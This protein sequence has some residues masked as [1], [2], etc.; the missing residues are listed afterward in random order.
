MERL[1]KFEYDN[2]IYEGLEDA[3]EIHVIKGSF[4]NHYEVSDK[5]HR[6]SDVRFLPPAVPSKIVCVGQNYLG[7]IEEL[8]AP[9]P[10]QP[11]IFLKP[12]SCLIGHEHPIIYPP[13]AGRIDYEGE[14]AIV[15][16]QRMKNVAE[17]DTLNYVLGYSCFN[18]VTERNMAAKDPFLLNLA[19]GFDSFGAL[20]PWIVTD[21]DPNHLELKTYLNGELKQQDNTQNC[22]FSIQR[23]LS[24]ISQYMTLLPGDV[25]IT[26]TPR[27]IAPMKPGDTV[28]VQI[29]S[30]GTL[31]NT[32]QSEA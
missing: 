13:I 16:K 9:V 18:D 30:I 15:I 1:V 23:V 11:L 31:R 21:L 29:E 32:V 14:L 6:I 20:G 12:P 8:G 2:K 19:K 5:K 3:E 24:F 4:W 28:E 7:H 26:G 10:R 17:T 25:V 22:V 27:G